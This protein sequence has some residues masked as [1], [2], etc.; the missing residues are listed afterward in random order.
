[1]RVTQK[2]IADKLGVK[3]MTVSRILAGKGTFSPQMVK[4]VRALADKLG[5]RPNASAQ[6]IRNG[7][8]YK[9]ICYLCNTDY[10]TFNMFNGNM[11]SNLEQELAK[12]GYSLSLATIDYNKLTDSDFLPSFLRNVMSDGLI[13]GHAR[14]NLREQVYQQFQRYKIPAVWANNF[15]ESDCV[16]FTDYEA[17]F[18]EVSRIVKT[19]RTRI[20]YV[21]FSYNQGKSWSD[22][23]YSNYQRCQGY[24]DS[25][26]NA[27]LQEIIYFKQHEEFSKA[28]WRSLLQNKI[29]EDELDGIVCYAD[30]IGLYALSAAIRC[31]K[32]PGKDISIFVFTTMPF[33]WEEEGV[34][35]LKLPQENMGYECAKMILR[36][37]SNPL[38][39]VPAVKIDF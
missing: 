30:A 29:I 39:T 27:G 22:I 31:G 7:E 33:E 25:V 3:Q 21:D 38:L 36:K 35:A 18:R 14:D 6:H 2:M 19:G 17:C 11:I 37:V 15:H 16:Y 24:L 8:C 4:K 12:E 28:D 32:E 10:P 26:H 13:M 20:A 23:H 1:M 34:T 5:Y 9:T